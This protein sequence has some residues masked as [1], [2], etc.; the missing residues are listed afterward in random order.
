MERQWNIIMPWR[1][2]DGGLVRGNGNSVIK[3]CSPHRALVRFVLKIALILD[4]IQDLTTE[5]EGSHGSFSIKG[6]N[7]I[8]FG[9]VCIVLTIS[10]IP[11]IVIDGVQWWHLK[12]LL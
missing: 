4:N 9:I 12:R 6:R 3:R 7:R 1:G 11:D 8:A 5:L 10:L 2:S